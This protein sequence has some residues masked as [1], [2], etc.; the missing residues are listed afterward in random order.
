MP[1]LIKTS[2]TLSNSGIPNPFEDL[3]NE[4]FDLGSMWENYMANPKEIPFPP[5]KKSHNISNF[6]K[7][8]L[9]DFETFLF[10]IKE[11]HLTTQESKVENI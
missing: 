1:N 10:A 5:I 2:W 11:S 6:T 9:E 4:H 7:F 3:F 8:I